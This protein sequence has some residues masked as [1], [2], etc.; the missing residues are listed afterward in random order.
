ME[1]AVDHGE[2]LW[3]GS[4]SDSGKFI[5]DGAV[6]NADPA[7]VGAHVGNG[8]AAQ[9]G[10]DGTADQHVG[11]V[12]RQQAHGRVAVGQLPRVHRF[13]LGLLFLRQSSDKD[14]SAVPDDLENFTFS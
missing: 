11:V 10:A 14:R 13:G 1:R 3:S 2:V 12:V 6:A 9:V 7:G 4:L 5:E 8:D